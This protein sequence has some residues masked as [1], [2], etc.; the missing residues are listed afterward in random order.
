M[1]AP[2]ADMICGRPSRCRASQASTVNQVT[3]HD[4][5]TRDMQLHFLPILIPVTPAEKKTPMPILFF[6]R[7]RRNRSSAISPIELLVS[8]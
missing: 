3:A 5:I 6:L 4:V 7:F 8:P 2:S 1:S